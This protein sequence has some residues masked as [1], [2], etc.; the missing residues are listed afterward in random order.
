[1]A[2]GPDVQGCLY[3]QPVR[4]W[5][6][7]RHWRKRVQLSTQIAANAVTLIAIAN[8]SGR[9]FWASCLTKSPASATLTWLSSY[10]WLG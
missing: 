2:T 4:H 6:S 9:L 8:L 5:R 1:M 10:H 3:K 7:K